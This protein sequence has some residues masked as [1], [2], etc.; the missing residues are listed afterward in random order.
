MRWSTPPQWLVVIRPL[1]HVADDVVPELT[2]VLEEELSGTPTRKVSL[3]DPRRGQWLRPPVQGLDRLVDDVF[4]ATEHLV[5]VTHPDNRW[6][7]NLVLARGRSRTFGPTLP[8]QSPRLCWRELS[9]PPRVRDTRRSRASV[10]D[11]VGAEAMP[12]ARDASIRRLQRI[13]GSGCAEHDSGVPQRAPTPRDRSKQAC[14][15][16][17]GRGCSRRQ[18]S[19][20]DGPPRVAPELPRRSVIGHYALVRRRRR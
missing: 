3:E 12:R 18:A 7:A 8:G 1:G 14:G 6:T 19:T 15:R 16:S 11:A 2:K 13:D 9:G 4:A 5:P 20:M 10:L 17:A